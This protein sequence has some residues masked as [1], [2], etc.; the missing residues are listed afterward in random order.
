MRLTRE[1]KL[2]IYDYNFEIPAGICGSFVMECNK[3]LDALNKVSGKCSVNGST[4]ER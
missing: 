3:Y 1:E 4:T 2:F